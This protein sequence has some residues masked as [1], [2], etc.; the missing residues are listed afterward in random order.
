MPGRN[1]HREVL[2]TQS[3]F[4]WM[5][6]LKGMHTRIAFVKVK[7][8]TKVWSRIRSGNS[9]HF[10]IFRYPSPIPGEILVLKGTISVPQVFSLP[11]NPAIRE[12]FCKIP[13]NTYRNSP[14]C[15]FQRLQKAPAV[16]GRISFSDED[17]GTGTGV[18]VRRFSSI[19][20]RVLKRATYSEI[21]HPAKILRRE[22][23]RIPSGAPYPCSVR[24][25]V[26]QHPL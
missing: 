5:I 24:S 17:S 22:L 19:R 15:A 9:P 21:V 4:S 25:H 11:G 12:Q 10:F 7:I 20:K 14:F 18:E 3:L 13:K 1:G 8:R 6:R 2:N 26:R 16:G 23:S